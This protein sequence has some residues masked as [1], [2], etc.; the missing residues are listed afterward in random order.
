M[1]KG[2]SVLEKSIKPQWCDG[3]EVIKMINNTTSTRPRKRLS[4]DVL[5]RSDSS[6]ECPIHYDTQRHEMIDDKNK[7]ET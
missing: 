7:G 1:K 2:C 6:H 4:L 3:E 5:S